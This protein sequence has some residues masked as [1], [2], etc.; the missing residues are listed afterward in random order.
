MR[1]RVSLDKYDFCGIIGCDTCRLHVVLGLYAFI[2]LAGLIW[3][4]SLFYN[5]VSEN[6]AI[7]LLRTEYFVG[8]NIFTY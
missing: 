2:V 7:T 5:H 6:D 1:F 8:D 3:S 4:L